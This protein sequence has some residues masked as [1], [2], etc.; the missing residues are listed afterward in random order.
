MP[1]TRES[2]RT[3]AADPRCHKE[4]KM[5]KIPRHHHHPVYNP[6]PPPPPRPAVPIAVDLPNQITSGFT[7]N[8]AVTQSGTSGHQ[9]ASYVAKPNDTVNEVLNALVSGLN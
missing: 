9:T 7:Y 5:T 3:C 2:S 6:P 8:L 4:R 1:R